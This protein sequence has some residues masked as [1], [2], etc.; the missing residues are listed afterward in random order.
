MRQ[1]EAAAV[2][3]RQVEAAAVLV[4]QDMVLPFR[5]RFGSAD[6]AAAVLVPQHVTTYK[7]ERLR[8]W[9]RNKSASGSM[10]FSFGR[11]RPLGLSSPFWVGKAVL[12]RHCEAAV[13]LVR[14][15]ERPRFWFRNKA[16]ANC[17]DPWS[18]RLEFRSTLGGAFD[19]HR[20]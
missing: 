4:P 1:D 5:C 9:F 17:R 13:V 15:V 16:L 10:T 6:G 14:L 3:G 12:V 2:L 20:L 18:F 7:L 11:F 19:T 8:F